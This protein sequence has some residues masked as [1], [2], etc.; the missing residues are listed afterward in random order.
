M[1]AFLRGEVESIGVCAQ[2]YEG[3]AAYFYSDKS[4]DSS[5]MSPL[6]KLMGLYRI[7]QTFRKLITAPSQNRS[8]RIH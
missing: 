2:P 1:E 5:L 7:N 3:R 6:S 4:T 8:Y